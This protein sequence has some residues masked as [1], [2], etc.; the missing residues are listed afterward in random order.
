MPNKFNIYWINWSGSK[1]SSHCRN[2]RSAPRS[3]FCCRG[4]A[5]ELG[6]V[7]RNS[8]RSVEERS[9]DRVSRCRNP[10]THSSCTCSAKPQLT[11][12]R[13]QNED[14]LFRKQ[15]PRRRT[16]RW[17]WTTLWNLL[18]SDRRKSNLQLEL[19]TQLLQQVLEEL[20]IHPDPGWQSRLRHVPVKWV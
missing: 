1:G 9:T 19:S 20:L 4:P 6:V 8:D 2:S 10:D 5:Q 14:A 17:R 11:I 3:P 13:V 12:V 15:F 7:M 16:T 18:W